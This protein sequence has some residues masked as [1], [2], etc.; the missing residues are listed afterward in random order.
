MKYFKYQF[1]G[2]MG[3]IWALFSDLEKAGQE[4]YE[5]KDSWNRCD[6]G[7]TLEIIRSAMNGNIFD[8]FG[9]NE[10]FNLKNYEFACQKQD[11]V[12]KN[13][14]RDKLDYIVELDS[15]EDKA[16]YKEVDSNTIRIEEDGFV[17]IEANEI[18]EK[19]LLE[20][21]T[22][23]FEYIV[24]EGID[25]IELLRNALR[26]IPDAIKALQKLNDENFKSLVASLCENGESGLLL[27]K[28]N[29]ML[30]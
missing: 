12:D 10:S 6:Y 18:F 4:T 15:S 13:N 26:G 14:D 24:N 22:M 29:E 1:Q 17:S 30:A 23:R 28:L 27:K 21:S 25:P 8:G 9:S 5:K 20:L 11:K 19:S 7:H 3:P 16:G 2:S